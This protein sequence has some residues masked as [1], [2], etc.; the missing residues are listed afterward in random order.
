MSLTD[1]LRRMVGAGTNDYTVGATAYWTD[2]QLQ[3]LLD[4]NGLS[5]HRVRVLLLRNADGTI[6][7][8]QVDVPG[9][10]EAGAEQ[11]T[12]TD[13]EGVELAGWSIDRNGLITFPA[14][15][16]STRVEWSGSS[17]DLNAAAADVLDAW[18]SAVKTAMDFTW[19][20]AGESVNGSFS[21]SQV[22]DRLA[23]R[24]AEFRAR[25]LAGTVE[26]GGGW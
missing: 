21:R 4:A 10:L 14:P 24:A 18:A 9:V 12:I 5:H 22:A 11:G 7:M 25:T 8:G 1:E 26:L 16:A 20:G 15:L 23:G 2:E 19:S 3:E 17:F 13:T 6:T